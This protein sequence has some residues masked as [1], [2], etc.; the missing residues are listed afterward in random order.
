MVGSV[1]VK[2]AEKLSSS[3]VELEEHLARAKA[4]DRS[5][6]RTNWLIAQE[7]LRRAKGAEKREETYRAAVA[8]AQATGNDRLATRLSLAAKEERGKRVQHLAAARKEALEGTDSFN[9]ID[10]LKQLAMICMR[11]AGVEE[12]PGARKRWEEAESYLEI[13]ARVKPDDFEAIE[14]LGMIKLHLEK[15]EELESLCE[16]IRYRH[17]Y[18][19][20]VYYYMAFIAREKR[21][22]EAYYLNLRQAYWMMKQ[23]TGAVFFPRRNLEEIVL[24]FGLVEPDEQETTAPLKRTLR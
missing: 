8:Q 24:K 23:E 13:V 3:E 1:S 17:P 7:Q 10:S 12:G 18:S 22:P 20:N 19:P 21:S 5:N 2:T 15:W 4:I 9:S 11:Q 16:Q 14:R 6:G